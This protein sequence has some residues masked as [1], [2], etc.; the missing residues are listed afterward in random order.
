MFVRQAADTSDDEV[1][2]AD[3]D[4]LWV[5]CRWRV[6]AREDAAPWF[7]AESSQKRTPCSALLQLGRNPQ[8]PLR[9]EFLRKRARRP[10]LAQDIA[11]S[12]LF[13]PLVLSFVL[14]VWE[15]VENHVNGA[16]LLCDA[17]QHSRSV[18]LAAILTEATLVF[19]LVRVAADFSTNTD[20]V[21]PTRSVKFPVHHR[22]H[23]M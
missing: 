6:D 8:T 16:R 13:V 18:T 9:S 23:H 2:V 1:V 14:C 17:S 21:M 20:P 10:V 22:N 3:N 15:N 4:T 5:M 11:C 19:L 7:P 12:T